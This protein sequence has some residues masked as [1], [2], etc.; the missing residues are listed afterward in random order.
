MC[1]WKSVAARSRAQPEQCSLALGMVLA[2]ALRKAAALQAVPRGQV[3]VSAQGPALS[4]ASREG[5][6]K[7]EEGCTTA[8]PQLPASY[9]EQPVCRKHG[10][11]PPWR[12]VM[13]EHGN[14]AMLRVILCT[15]RGRGC[16][17]ISPPH[18]PS[19]GLTP[20]GWQVPSLEAA[21]EHPAQPACGGDMTVG[22]ETAHSIPN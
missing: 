1:V 4:M 21:Q 11:V 19:T 10:V 22:Y 5:S 9:Q 6:S 15:S 7:E 3:Q 2:M 12:W 16:F 13:G 20:H 14:Q 18:T 17:Q 8:W